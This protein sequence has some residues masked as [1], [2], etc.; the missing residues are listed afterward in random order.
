MRPALFLTIVT[1]A[2]CAGMGAAPGASARSDPEPAGEVAVGQ[3]IPALSFKKLLGSGNVS[4]AR[5]RGKVVLL[6]LWA[7]W[8]APCKE[9]LPLLDELAERLA[10]RGVEIVAVSLDEDR[11]SA[12]AFV[13]RAARWRLTLAHDPTGATGDR[14]R[15]AVMPSSYVIDR[16]GVLRAVQAGFQRGD[17]RALEQMLLSLAAR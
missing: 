11:A 2:G 1:A 16:G 6:D 8:C 14:L 4:L 10:G 15:P 12:E 17:E 13:R 5:L 3:P 7:S 9:E